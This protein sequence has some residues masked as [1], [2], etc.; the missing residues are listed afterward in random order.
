MALEQL[1]SGG[2]R[3]LVASKLRLLSSC[4]DS[5]NRRRLAGQSPLLPS[6]FL[7]HFRPAYDDLGLADGKDVLLMQPFE[8]DGDP[9]P[10]RADHVGKIGVREGGAN[11]D[12][13]LFLEAVKIH[14]MK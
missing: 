13:I 9:L 4:A 11:Q 12:A 3:R 5:F 2:K 7:Q 10:C 6:H 14:Q 8:A 1:S